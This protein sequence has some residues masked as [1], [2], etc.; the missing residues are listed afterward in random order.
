MDHLI[1]LGLLH[2]RRPKLRAFSARLADQVD[3]WM[4]QQ[5]NIAPIFYREWLAGQPGASR[6]GEV[7]G[8]LG[9]TPSPEV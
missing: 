6:S 8:S 5:P 4:V 1:V 7:L 9:V 3:S 2:D